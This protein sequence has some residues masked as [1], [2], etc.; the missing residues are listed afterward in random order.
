MREL[1]ITLL[2]GG[3]VV[4]MDAPSLERLINHL[5]KLRSEMHPHVAEQ[6]PTIGPIESVR[7]PM[8]TIDVDQFRLDPVLQ[9]RDTRFGWVNYLM[10]PDMARG[11][12]HALTLTAQR[13]EALKLQPPTSAH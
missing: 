5:G 1:A 2:E 10:A 4:R 12:A 9:V 8:F 6:R 13:A 11:L 7:D 3:S